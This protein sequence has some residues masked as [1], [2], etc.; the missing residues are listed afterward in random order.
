M[1][2]LGGGGIE[3]VAALLEGREG[4]GVEHFRPHV[5]V[6]GRRIAAAGEDMTEMRRAVAHHDLVGHA[7]ARQ[8]FFLERGGID[9]LG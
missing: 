6:I 9:R 8:R 5:A 7:D 4:I 3:N 2:P 1:Q